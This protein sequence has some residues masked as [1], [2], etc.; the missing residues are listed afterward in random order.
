LK[1]TRNIRGLEITENTR[2]LKT[3]RNT[4]GLEIDVNTRGLKTAKNTRGLT[5]AGLPGFENRWEITGVPRTAKKVTV[6]PRVSK[7]CR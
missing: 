7:N 4:R 6:L 1:T 3:A 2:S 5:I